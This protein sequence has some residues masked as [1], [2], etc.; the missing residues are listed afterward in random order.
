[1]SLLKKFWNPKTPS[2]VGE[3][4]IDRKTVINAYQE[5]CRPI[6]EANGFQN[7]KKTSAWRYRNKVIDVVDLIFFPSTKVQLWG[8]NPNSFAIS[9]G[10]FYPFIPY[11]GSTIPIGKD[12][13]L[14]PP[15][16][17]C[18]ERLTPNRRMKQETH[19]NPNIW[20]IAPDGSNLQ[21][22]MLDVQAIL[23]NELLPHLD[24]LGDLHKRLN[25]M[26]AM[27]ENMAKVHPGGYFYRGFLALETGEWEIAHDSLQK[28]L[29]TGFY[30]KE[31]GARLANPPEDKIREAI[32][33][34]E[35]AIA[36]SA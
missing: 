21:A 32:A 3:H 6:L 9:G 17:A 35:A 4:S 20:D 1:M 25:E 31:G 29:A 34:A 18:T 23:Q 10:V 28:A 24:R 19:K 30:S 12:G 15:E 36:A 2:D 16:I 11:V 26:L 22:V 7:F 14:L 13:K 5:F 27:H 33:K 8:I